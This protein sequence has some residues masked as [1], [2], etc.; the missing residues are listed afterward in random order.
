MESLPTESRDVR[1]GVAANTFQGA[2]G[3]VHWYAEVW[4]VRVLADGFERTVRE[5]AS[6]PLDADA[7]EALNRADRVFGRDGNPYEAGNECTR[8]PNRRE[9]VAA[10]LRMLLGMNGWKRLPVSDAEPEDLDGDDAFLADW[11]S[12]ER[13]GLVPPDGEPVA[14]ALRVAPPMDVKDGRVFNPFIDAPVKED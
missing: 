1:H 6:A 9:A 7:A 8:F 10:G 3:A 13:E 11:E 2:Y 14:E 4:Q 5:P 12:Y